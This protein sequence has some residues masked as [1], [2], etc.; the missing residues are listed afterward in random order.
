MDSSFNQYMGYGQGQ[1]SQQAGAQQQGLGS[2]GN[3]SGSTQHT[4]SQSHPTLP[5]LQSQNGGQFGNL[6][7][8]HPGSAAHTPTTPHTPSMTMPQSATSSYA[9][10]SPAHTQGGMLPPSSFAQPYNLAQ[11]NMYPSSTGASLPSSTATQGLPSLRPMPPGGAVGP[12][13]GLPSLTGATQLGQQ[14]SFGQQGDDAP[15]HVVGSQGR[16]GVLPTAPGR[17][18]PPAQGATGKSMIPQKDADGKFP[19]PHCNK[20]YLHAKHLKRHL[21]RHTGDRPYMCHLCKDT[22]S[23]SDILKRHFQKCSIRRGNPTG[24][25]HLAHQRRNN[26]AGNRLSIS[27]QEGPIG[28]AGLPEVAGSGPPYANGMVSSPTV[29][30][31]MSGRSTRANSLVTPNNMSHRNSVAGLGILGSNASGNDQ[32]GTSAASYQPNM[33]AYAMHNVSN[34]GQMPPNY[35]YSQPQMNG[36]TYNQQQ[37]SFLGHPS[38]RYDTSH[39][40]NAYQHSTNGDGGGGTGPTDWSRMFNQ[41]GQ[42]GF[43]SSQPA[44]A[45]SHGMM[46]TKTDVTNDVK[47]N[48]N[49]MHNDMSND[50]F[51]GSLY[52]HPSAFGSEYGVDHENG[53]LPGFP[54]WSVDD[55]LQAKVD[56]LMHYC[57]P[58]GADTTPGDDSSAIVKACLTAENIKHFA[59][60]FKSYQGHWPVLHMPTFK[61]TEANNA[62]V[63]AMLCIGAVY[64]PQMDVSRVRL[65][66][67]FVKMTVFNNSSIYSRYINGST[68]GLGAESWDVEELQALLMLQTIYTWH[69]DANQRQAA[70]NEFPALVHLAKAMGMTQQA[71]QGHYAYSPLHSNMTTSVDGN[72]FNWYG[73]LEQEKRNRVLYMLFLSDAAMVMF[74]NNT[75]QFDP[76]EVRLMLPADDAAW[77]AGDAQECA[78]ALGLHGVHAQAQHIAGTRRPKQPGMREAMRTLLDPTASFQPNATNV[79]SKFVLIHALITRLIACQKTLMASDGQFQGMNFN[80]GSSSPATPLSQND[81]LDMHGGRSGNVSSSNSGHVTPTDGMNMQLVAVQQERTRLGKALDKWKRAWDQDMDLQYPPGQLRQRRFGF[82]RDGV[83]F[84]YLGRSFYQSQRPSDWTTPP[85]K[86]FQQTMALLKRI[87][88]FVLGDN[89]HKGHDIGSVGDIDDQ[90]GLDDLTLDM[91]LLFKPYNSQTDRSITGVQTYL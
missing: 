82:S 87:K 70:R 66:M 69:G 90:Y 79:Y 55:P 12:M 35:A 10:M 28:L 60:H 47:P 74:F 30:G 67:D 43:M 25:N 62:L 7:Y 44:N 26:N 42:D 27:Q 33:S 72:S 29:A 65:M 24:A 59:E 31:D 23:R 20:T 46:H 14:S 40:N 89:E 53:I 80:A 84:F 39:N 91:K 51:L 78:N 63:L 41:G 32:M 15:T 37:M 73:W 85:D 6:S 68:N 83:H 88:G 36:S 45:S 54:N 77:D 52:S 48:F 86:R 17:P 76:L 34:G 19:C 57:F 61:L 4:D 56:S 3:L 13:N 2:F 8:M 58:N 21:L 75:P 81:W 38:S 22:F 71:E 11:S 18:N 1:Q 50:S 16:R 5:P 9:T 49:N 64:S